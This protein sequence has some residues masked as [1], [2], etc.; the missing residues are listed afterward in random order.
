MLWFIGGFIVASIIWLMTIGGMQSRIVYVRNGK[1]WRLIAGSN[2]MNCD[3]ELSIKHLVN[4]YDVRGCGK[5][6]SVFIGHKE[7]M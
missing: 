4:G 6:D 7:V 2:F 5:C 3:H 1:M